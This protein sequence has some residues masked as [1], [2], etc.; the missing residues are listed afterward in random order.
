M[1]F[2]RLLTALFLIPIT[3]FLTLQSNHLLFSLA[4][5][6]VFALASFEYTSLI[7]LQN[8]WIRL[9][10][11]FSLL[12]FFYFLNR[13]AIEFMPNWMVYFLAFSSLW[14]AFNCYL[15]IVFPKY[16]S[17]FKQGNLIQLFTGVMIFIPML[18]SLAAIHRIDN[19][20]LLLLFL[21]VWSS[22]VGGYFFGKKLGK[23]KLSPMVSPG[24]T[25]EGALGGALLSIFVVNI[26]VYFLFEPSAIDQYFYFSI[27]SIIV[28]CASILGDLLESALKRLSNKK[29]SGRLLPG[30]GGI[31]DRTDS[32][33]AAAPFFFIVYVIIT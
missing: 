21:L 9:I 8:R 16:S 22:D 29:D 18:V 23:Y 4:I 31:F 14:W 12:L 10:Y 30:H 3:L 32:L 17:V 19:M 33:T 11:V 7:G 15:I 20:A 13:Q 26:F 24:K 27:L 6:F 2:K 28:S 25:I 1:L 5:M